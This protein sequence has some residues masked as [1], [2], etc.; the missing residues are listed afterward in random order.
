MILT[1]KKRLPQILM[2]V[3]I[4]FMTLFTNGIQVDAE[5]SAGNDPKVLVVYSSQSGEVNDNVRMLDLLTGHFTMNITFINTSEIE[6]NDLKNVTHLFYFGQMKEQLPNSFTSILD[7][8][9]GTVVALGHNVAQLG[10]RFSF[11]IPQGEAIFSKVLLMGKGEKVESII[12]HTVLNVNTTKETEELIKVTHGSENVYP[13]FVKNKQNYYYASSDIKPP[14]SI[15][16]GEVLHEVFDEEHENVHPGYIRLED[17]HPMVNVEKLMAVAEELKK[18]DIPYLVAVIPVYTNPKTHEEYHMSDFPHVIKAL[19]YMQDNGGNIVMHGYTHQFRKSETGEGYEFWD[20]ENNMP[21]YHGPNEKVIKKTKQDFDTAADYEMYKKEQKEF[22]KKYVE[23]KLTKGIQELTNYGIYPLAFEAP[24]Y[25]MSQNGYAVTSNHFSTYVGQVQVSD[26][27]WE[28]MTTAPYITMPSFLK[29]MTLLPET[30]GYVQP[31]DSKVIKRMIN[32]AKQYSIVR[33]GMVAAFF[34][35]SHP[36]LDIN[37]FIKLLD[38]MEKIPGIEWIDLKK[39][40][41]TVTADN[42]KI[43]TDNGKR[44]DNIDNLGLYMSSFDYFLYHFKETVK[45]LTWWMVGVGALAVVLFTIYTFV[46]RKRL[47][48]GRFG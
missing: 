12:P 47:R 1:H 14:L 17:I 8:F 31:N 45:G 10:K 42:V 35:P 24:H 28:I 41:H 15:Y 13:L 18:R 26:E 40:D 3:G 20:V 30:M 6:E 48:R 16:L 22:E 4:L 2:L 9:N 29:G 37:D 36:D 7:S 34:H 27:D 44:I 33:D 25:T 39:M 38:R 23:E 32:D 46:T 11:V 21:I 19:K 5:N 43:E